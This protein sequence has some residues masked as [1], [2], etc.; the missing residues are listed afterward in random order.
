[1]EHQLDVDISLLIL[2]PTNYSGQTVLNSASID[3]IRSQWLVYFPVALIQNVS[4]NGGYVRPYNGG[5]SMARPD[6]LVANTDNDLLE[7]LR[8]LFPHQ[9]MEMLGTDSED[10]VESHLKGSSP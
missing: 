4:M 8:Q 6:V 5:L 7:R 2:D 3:N 10:E 9:N 1:M